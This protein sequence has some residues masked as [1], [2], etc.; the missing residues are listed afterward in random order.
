[1]SKL[2]RLEA[3]KLLRQTS[4]YVCAAIAVGSALLSAFTYWLLDDAMAQMGLAMNFSSSSFALSGLSAATFETL[5][6]IVIALNVCKDHTQQ[7]V[8]IVCGR[9]Y[10]RTKIYWSK[11]ATSL[12][13]TTVL[14]VVSMAFSALLG[15]CFFDGGSFDGRFFRIVAV[16]YLVSLAEGVLFFGICMLI[17][18]SGLS[19]TTVVIAP[20]IVPIVLGLLNAAIQPEGFSFTD[21][22]LTNCLAALSFDT[23]S[24]ERITE[25]VIT[26]LCY[27]PPCAVLPS[28]L[29][30]KFEF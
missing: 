10:S 9:G 18:K 28:L 16:Q 23:V 8:R 4:L 3:R 6:G 29:Y 20:L 24:A 7:T 21:F 17:R 26:A 1:M 12:A 13:I 11:L 30:R 2:L 27:I 25:C 5:L 15:I 19:I 14:F 22:W